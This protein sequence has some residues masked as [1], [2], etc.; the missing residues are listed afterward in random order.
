MFSVKILLWKVG[1]GVSLPACGI[2]AD[3]ISAG[4]NEAGMV[5]TRAPIS[6]E[7]CTPLV[8]SCACIQRLDSGVLVMV[9]AI[10]SQPNGP[11]DWCGNRMVVQNC[12]P[13]D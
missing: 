12:I 7:T 8:W 10:T 1:I 13:E 2:N 11:Y 9:V 4:W 6:T 3:G 5:L